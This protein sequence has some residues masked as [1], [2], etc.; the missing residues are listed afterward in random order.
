MARYDLGILEAEF[1]KLTFFELNLLLKR[2]DWD[3]RFRAKCGGL[4][5]EEERPATSPEQRLMNFRRLKAHF[6]AQ[7][8]K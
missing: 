6:E 2:W 4:Q 7:K 3:V 8:P 1:W 5:I